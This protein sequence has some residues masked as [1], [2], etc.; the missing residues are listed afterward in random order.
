[1]AVLMEVDMADWTVTLDSKDWMKILAELQY[2]NPKIVSMFNKAMKV[3]A[4]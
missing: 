3:E 4:N 1:M 2:S